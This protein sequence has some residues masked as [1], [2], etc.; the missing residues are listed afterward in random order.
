[1]KALALALCI[2]ASL[3]AAA[4]ARDCAGEDLNQA[5]L[6]QCSGEA[7][8]KADALLNARYKKIVGCLMDKAKSLVEA[9]RAWVKFRDSECAFQGSA[10]EGGSFQPTAINTCLK[11]VT[12]ARA[13]ELN[14]YLTC[15]E[16]DLS[17]PSSAC[18]FNDKPA[19]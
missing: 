17:C 1:M 7:F 15:E 5:G 10:S 3:T 16:G 13:K 4:L 9:Q 2:H 6:N 8:Q 12:E 14:F 11:S 19:K 18:G